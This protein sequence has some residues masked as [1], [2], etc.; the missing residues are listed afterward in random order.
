VVDFEDL[1]IGPL[2]E[3]LRTL[4]VARHQPLDQSVRGGTQ[5]DGP[6]LSR[7][8]PELRDIRARLAQAVSDYVAAL[9]APEPAH[10]LLGRIPRHARFVGSWSVRLTGG[11][12][13]EPHVHNEGWLSSA[14]YVALPDSGPDS[15]AGWL[16]LGEPQASLGLGL[17]PVRSIE[18][19]PG[20]LVL[21]PS[22]LWHGT[23]PF[24]SGERMTI[25]FDIG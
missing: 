10:P 13:H 25:A 15:E 6:L 21:F 11:G 19:K 5:T 4:H 17:P 8:D 9:P 2:A 23:R 14:F 12:F 18:P 1:A 7:L 22:T 20:R 3:R 16:T 24:A